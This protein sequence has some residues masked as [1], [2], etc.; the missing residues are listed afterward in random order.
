MKHF[1]NEYALLVDVVLAG[2]QAFALHPYMSRWPQSVLDGR[3]VTLTMVCS[4]LFSV[5]QKSLLVYC[6]A[7]AARGLVLLLF[8]NMRLAESL[9]AI[10]GLAEYL[11]CGSNCIRAFIAFTGLVLILGTQRDECEECYDLYDWSMYLYIVL[12]IMGCYMGSCCACV[13]VLFFKVPESLES[14]GE[15]QPFG[16]SGTCG[17][18]TEDD[19]S[20]TVSI[21]VAPAPRHGQKSP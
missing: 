16:P 21:E 13:F 12:S 10:V 19:A 8:L 3:H 7:S 18:Y 4:R 20:S 5:L 11:A 9:T 14:D 6:A 1:V 17:S 2:L 15:N